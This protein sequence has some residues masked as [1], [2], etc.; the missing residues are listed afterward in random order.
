MAPQINEAALTD[1]LLADQERVAEIR[2]AAPAELPFVL[3]VKL[4][5]RILCGK[6]IPKHIP[7]NGSTKLD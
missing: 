7:L 6:P 5:W 1:E 3:L 4:I 2:T